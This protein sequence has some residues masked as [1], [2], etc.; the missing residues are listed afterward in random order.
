MDKSQV[1]AWMFLAV[2]VSRGPDGA[3]A[4]EDVVAAADWV[5][6]AIPLQDELTGGLN[7]LLGA[8]FLRNTSDS[9]ALSDT[10]EALYS[11]VKKRAGLSTQFK[12]L[13]EAFES[14]PAAD[15]LLWTPGAGAIDRAIDAY[16]T[17][18]TAIIAGM[19]NPRTRRPGKARPS[20]SRA[21]VVYEI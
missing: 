2:A 15:V 9:F 1:N 17:R 18:A 8:G 4:L 21:S 7:R 13:K 19:S 3:A 14:L 6:H 16:Q 5:N 10:G 20:A 11:R 12:R